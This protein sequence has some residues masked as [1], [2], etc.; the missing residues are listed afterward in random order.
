VYSNGNHK[1]FSNEGVS[2]LLNLGEFGPLDNANNG[3][4]RRDV[5]NHRMD[6]VN[7]KINTFDSKIRQ[8]EEELN[9]FNDTV[10]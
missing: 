10:M 9:K 1:G 2:N 8:Q 6:R 5:N 4:V 3:N 7:G